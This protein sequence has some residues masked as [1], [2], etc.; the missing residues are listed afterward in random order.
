MH[1]LRQAITQRVQ[2]PNNWVLGLW[3]VVIVVQVLGRYMVNYEV[4]W[5]FRVTTPWQHDLQ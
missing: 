4:L 3:V 2:V 5:T 1:P